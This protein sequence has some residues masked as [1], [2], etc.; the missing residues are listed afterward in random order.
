MN[1]PAPAYGK[2]PLQVVDRY[3]K[4]I[5]R[6]DALPG[7]NRTSFG[8]VIPWRDTGFGFQFSADGHVHTPGEDPRAELR[9]ISPGFFAS[10]GVPI[11][12]GRDFNERD[13]KKGSEPVVIVSETLA[14]R[15]FPN[16]DAVDRHV[17]WT[18]PVLEFAPFSA[19]PHRVIGVTAD[20]DDQHIVPEPVLTVY[21]P[22][23]EG[24]LFGGHLFI[25]PSADPYS[26]VTPVTRTICDI[27][28]EQPLEHPATLHDVRAAARAPSRSHSLA[29]T[30]FAS[31][32]LAIA[33][34]GVAG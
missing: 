15:M 14:K 7:V 26:L 20:I 30:V 31:V 10:L 27:S 11:L 16:Q 9:V 25:H 3:G 17:F 22:F 8:M 29:F 32:A 5:R 12:S 1:V 19:A 34:V 21:N 24:P 33:L 4:A 6:I 13:G 28:A 23:E 18:D 2:T